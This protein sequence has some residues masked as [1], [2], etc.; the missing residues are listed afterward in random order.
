M[1]SM[2]VPTDRTHDISARIANLETASREEL[3]AAW[4]K[5]YRNEPPK[6]ASRRLL[7]GAVAHALQ[8]RT[9]GLSAAKLRRRLERHEKQKARTQNPTARLMPGARLIREWNGRTH[10][11]DVIEGGYRWNGEYYRSLSAIAR[12]ITGT[13]WSGPRFF[14]LDQKGPG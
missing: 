12:A 6:G 11:V 13:R 4:R 5:S 10:M 14:G 8:M 1:T 7:F 3:A 2:Q 9:H